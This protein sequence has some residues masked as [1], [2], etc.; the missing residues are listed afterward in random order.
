MDQ[1]LRLVVHRA[2]KS[3]ARNNASSTAAHGEI[4]PDGSAQRLGRLEPPVAACCASQKSSMNPLKEAEA[5]VILNK[6]VHVG[7]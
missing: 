2:R 7:F 1:R 3:P 4:T 5:L 6:N